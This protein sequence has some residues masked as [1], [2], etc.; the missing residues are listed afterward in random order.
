MPGA[1][2]KRRAPRAV[3]GE[4]AVVPGLPGIE[5]RSNRVLEW[6]YKGFIGVYDSS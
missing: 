4:P 1:S 5:K 2:P 3:R 6:I